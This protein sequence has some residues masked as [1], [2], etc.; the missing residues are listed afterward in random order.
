MVLNNTF[1][2]DLIIMQLVTLF[3]VFMLV[4]VP[5]SL[6]KPLLSL[7]WFPC[8][9]YA[10]IGV[11]HCLEQRKSQEPPFYKMEMFGCQVMSL[12]HTFKI[13][14]FFFLFAYH[15][16][17]SL[18]SPTTSKR[19]KDTSPVRVSRN[20]IPCKGTAKAKTLR[21]EHVHVRTEKRPVWLE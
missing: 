15:L 13:V 8:R 4:I 3:S 5:C 1:Y 17:F 16:C 21:W 7:P 19:I 9:C 6:G 12:L 11:T 10:T 20:D 2:P 14:L 18:N